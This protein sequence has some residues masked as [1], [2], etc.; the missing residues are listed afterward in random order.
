MLSTL[1]LNHL[2]VWLFSPPLCHFNPPAHRA[3]HALAFVVAAH[4]H[5]SRTVPFLA[6]TTT[7]AAPT[8][9]AIGGAVARAVGTATATAAATTAPLDGRSP[10][11]QAS[12]HAA[13]P[14]D[15]KR[16]AWSIRVSQHLSI[17]RPLA[18]RVRAGYPRSG[19]S[20]TGTGASMRAQA[21]QARRGV[22]TACH[23]HGCIAEANLAFIGSCA[24]GRS[25][26]F[27][28]FCTTR[29]R[30]QRRRRRRR[31]RNGC[32]SSS[33]RIQKSRAQ[34]YSALREVKLRDQSN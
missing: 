22:A 1:S 8:A 25:C 29:G 16:P 3:R 26:W 5:T 6:S 28:Q 19:V 2:R 20:A 23:F 33:G 7:V 21:V 32:R 24:R 4:K 18:A 12:Q 15:R 14:L 10:F 9:A 30:R 11:G 27:G 17:Q 34:R 31:R 13:Q